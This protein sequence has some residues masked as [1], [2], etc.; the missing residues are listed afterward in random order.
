MRHGLYSVLRA[1]APPG[2][3]VA[4][5]MYAENA[6]KVNAALAAA[7]PA[8]RLDIIPLGRVGSMLQVRQRLLDGA[9]VGILGDRTR[10]ASKAISSETRLM[11][12]LHQLL[13]LCAR[14]LHVQLRANF[15]HAFENRSGGARLI[16]AVRRGDHQ[17]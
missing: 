5:V 15:Q 7:N 13:V 14:T 6:R 2:H 4:M 12:V 11:R 17:L 16:P 8:A 1:R 9:I 10:L 3:D